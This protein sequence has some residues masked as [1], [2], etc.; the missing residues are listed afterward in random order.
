MIYIRWYFQQ[1]ANHCS[2]IYFVIQSKMLFFYESIVR[3]IGIIQQCSLSNHCK[4]K[5][6][7]NVPGA[8]RN[9]F[10]GVKSIF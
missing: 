6:P 1:R 3:G 2:N 9:D 8:G 5:I 10:D 7:I 4:Y